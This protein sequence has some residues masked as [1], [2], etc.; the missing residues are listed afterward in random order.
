[1]AFHPQFSIRFARFSVL[2]CSRAK[3][4]GFPTHGS[5]CGPIR[6]TSTGERLRRAVPPGL[7]RRQTDQQSGFIGAEG[8]MRL[9][10]VCV[11]SISLAGCVAPATQGQAVRVAPIPPTQTPVG[12][13]SGAGRRIAYDGAGNFLLPDGSVVPRDASGGFTLPNGAYA[14][15]DGAGGVILPNGTRCGSDRAGGYLCP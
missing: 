10:I 6:N 12:A 15:P 4:P 9:W 14:T 5:V 3:A 11:V 13:G 2:R 7:T 8:R 1:M